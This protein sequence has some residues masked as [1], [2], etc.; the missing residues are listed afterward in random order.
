MNKYELYSLATFGNVKQVLAYYFNIKDN[1][2]DKVMAR[3]YK[4]PVL[5]LWAANNG[6]DPS[7]IINAIELSLDSKNKLELKDLDED[8]YF[9]SVLHLSNDIDITLIWDIMD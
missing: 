8:G 2:Y 4:S 1:D 3:I 7:Q 9:T 5:F 6:V